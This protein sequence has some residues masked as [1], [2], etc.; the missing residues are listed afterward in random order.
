M[1]IPSVSVL[2]GRLWN[3]EYDPTD[4]PAIPGDP[5]AGKTAALRTGKLASDTFGIVLAVSRVV[6]P[7][8]LAFPPGS[9]EYEERIA[10]HAARVEREMATI[11][12]E[13]ESDDTV[14]T[15][16]PKRDRPNLPQRLGVR[17]DDMAV[18][19]CS[20]CGVRL[21]GPSWEV[22]RR[23]VLRPARR[24]KADRA[25]LFAKYGRFFPPPV[26]GYYRGR[27]ECGPC[28]QGG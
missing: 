4:L 12:R 2:N 26:G 28:F 20:S 18:L 7:V 22:V 3:S 23:A 6:P 8:S 19:F 14:V 21:L 24:H 17:W 9:P 5:H 1:A 27:P 10:Y 15:K 11:G 13:D 25:A 16:S